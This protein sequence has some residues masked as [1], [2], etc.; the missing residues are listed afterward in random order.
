ML[1]NIGTK[2]FPT[3]DSKEA[4]SRVLKK[5]LMDVEKDHSVC[6]RELRL[7]KKPNRRQP[8]LGQ[9][10]RLDSSFLCAG[11][12]RNEDTCIGDGGSPLVCPGKV[13][14]DGY[15]IYFQVRF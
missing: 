11:G 13:E 1:D 2:L 3:L 9:T 5:I 15:P 6:E 7:A 4:K 14:V 10:F 12:N 8:T